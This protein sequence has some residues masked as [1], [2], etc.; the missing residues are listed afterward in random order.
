[1]SSSKR[2][3]LLIDL[4]N[5]LVV[6]FIWFGVVRWGA[7]T[8]HGAPFGPFWSQACLAV[9]LFA[10]L[11]T[12]VL[13]ARSDAVSKRTLKLG[14]RLAYAGAAT[15]ALLAMATLFTLRGTEPAWYVPLVSFFAVG[16]LFRIAMDL[17]GVRT[18]AKPEGQES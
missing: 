2:D 10:A 12:A 1:V 4:V 8:A 9:T 6:A 18:R 13:V 17:R 5:V 7:D 15:M 16:G 14:E 11:V 3:I